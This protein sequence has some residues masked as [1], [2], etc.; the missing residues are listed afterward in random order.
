[1]HVGRAEQSVPGGV[2]GE[3]G[4]DP[5]GRR[6][7]VDLGQALGDARVSLA[8]GSLS[9]GCSS[10]GCSATALHSPLTDR[11]G[12]PPTGAGRYAGLE[13]P[14]GPQ[15][16]GDGPVPVAPQHGPG[17][18]LPAARRRVRGSSR[19]SRSTSRRVWHGRS[20]DPAIPE[21]CC[22]LRP[23]SPCTSTCT[24]AWSGRQ[25]TG[26]SPSFV[27]P[28]ARTGRGL[29]GG[30]PGGPEERSPPLGATGAL[31]VA[32]VSEDQRLTRRWS[33]DPRAVTARGW[34]PRCAAP[35]A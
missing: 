1:M 22:T 10:T 34:P 16:S 26:L 28:P 27:P 33:P 30:R 14:P 9:C 13:E 2:I 6:R 8:A 35:A 11:P 24:P 17:G 29:G 19:T 3:L 7:R 20:S 25:P 21:A 5:V 18:R 32:F 31:E 4:R 12:V 23:R 15:G